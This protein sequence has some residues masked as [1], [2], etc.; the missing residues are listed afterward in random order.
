MATIIET[1]ANK[2]FVVLPEDGIDHAWRGYAVKRHNGGWTRK[3]NA[4]IVLVR[5]AGCVQ[6]F[7]A[8]VKE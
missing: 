7:Q 5:K 6:M 4:K 2:F 1:S 3:T 8:P